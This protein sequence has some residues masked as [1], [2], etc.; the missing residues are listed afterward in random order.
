MGVR[1]A[2]CLHLPRDQ[3][4]NESESVLRFS[5]EEIHVEPPMDPF[6]SKVLSFLFWGTLLMAVLFLIFWITPIQK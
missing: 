3:A 4:M 5:E 6:L 2:D 1:A